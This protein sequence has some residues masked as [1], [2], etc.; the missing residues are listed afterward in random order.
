MTRCTPCPYSL[1]PFTLGRN[2]SGAGCYGAYLGAGTG[3]AARIFRH[4]RTGHRLSY[5]VGA[6]A[7]T[8]MLGYFSWR[9]ANRLDGDGARPDGAWLAMLAGLAVVYAGGSGVGC[10]CS[11]LGPQGC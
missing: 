10:R 3:G 9:Q 5:M 1:S 8:P 7:G 11:C 6:T 2:V 4:P